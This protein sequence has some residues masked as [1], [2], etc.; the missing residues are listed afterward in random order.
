MSWQELS[1]Q[2]RRFRL[3]RRFCIR[4][5]GGKL[6]VIDDAADGRQSALSADCN[7][8]DLCTAIQPG[9]HVRLFWQ[10]FRT[11]QP[12]LQSIDF[13]T[14]GEDL[15]HA[16]RHVPMTPSESWRCIV[17]YHDFETQ[18]PRFSKVLRPTS[19]STVIQMS[20]GEIQSAGWQS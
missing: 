18:Q 17:A 16:Y 7:R 9:I 11:H 6:R 1:A 5:P 10:A 2:G 3:I 13:E 8:L 14:G 19:S 12:H 4:Q 20:S 15:P